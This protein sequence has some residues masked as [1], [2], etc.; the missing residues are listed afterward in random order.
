MD[1][2]NRSELKRSA[3][4]ALA[5]GRDPKKLVTT[6]ALALTAIAAIL[7]LVNAWVSIQYEG[8]GGLGNLGL[9]S[10]LGTVQ[11]V[12]PMVQTVLV[13]CVEF[14]YLGGMLR[15]ARGQYA[16]HTDLKAGFRRF[17]PILRLTLL[18]GFLYFGMGFVSL[19]LAMNIFLLTPMAGPLVELLMPIIEAGGTMLDDATLLQANQMMIPMY[20]LFALLFLVLAMPMVFRLRMANYVLMDNPQAGAFAAFRESRKMMRGNCIHLLKLDLSFWWFYV[21]DVFASALSYGDVILDSLGIPLPFSAEVSAYIF[22]GLYLAVLF[23]I[24]YFLRNQVEATY[25]MAYDSIHEKPQD[26]GVVLGNIFDM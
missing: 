8:T 16:D 25:I 23:A 3:A 2:R 22:Y 26:Q 17:G 20:I 19:Y 9:R 11:T 18:Q 15:I 7:T 6:Y 12:L 5:R 4:R 21:L 10:M 13:L 1:I 14:G 24:N